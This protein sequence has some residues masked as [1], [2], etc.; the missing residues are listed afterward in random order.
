MSKY[1]LDTSVIVKWF[2][3]EE[4]D[5]IATKILELLQNKEITIILPELTKY[6]FSNVLLKGKKYSLNK[7]NSILQAF[8]A[9][10]V[11]YEDMDHTL[12]KKTY[13]IAD[14]LNIT[15]YDAV[16]LALADKYSAP[17]VTANPKHQ[18]SYKGIKVIPLD[19]FKS[20]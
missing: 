18:K 16:F 3:K 17:L 15:Y 6:E 2:F 19:K 5:E 7:A 13:T 8:Y 14:G 11:I 20:S 9:I 12:A 1:I 10:P 4:H